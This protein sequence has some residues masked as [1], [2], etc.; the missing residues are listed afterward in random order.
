MEGRKVCVAY[1]VYCEDEWIADLGVVH[2]EV[3]ACR[4]LPAR[5]ADKPYRGKK[6]NG[7]RHR[8]TTL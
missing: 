4:K 6:K 1:E 7:T 8:A 2:V 5:N 3:G